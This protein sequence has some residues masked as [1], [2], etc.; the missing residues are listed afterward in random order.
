MVKVVYLTHLNSKTFSNV[1][2]AQRAWRA[3]LSRL[4]LAAAIFS[5]CGPGSISFQLNLAGVSVSKTVP[6]TVRWH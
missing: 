6:A 1:L 2:T 3:Y 4:H 5:S